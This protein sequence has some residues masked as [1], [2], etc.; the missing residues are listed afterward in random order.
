MC[1]LR[2]DAEDKDLQCT[3][4]LDTICDYL[5]ASSVEVNFDT[6]RYIKNS[7]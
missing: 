3:D 5:K 7:I 1:L 4:N 2:Y 6:I